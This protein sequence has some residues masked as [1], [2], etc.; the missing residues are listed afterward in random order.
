MGKYVEKFQ[1]PSPLVSIKTD[2]PSAGISFDIYEKIP[3]HSF[4]QWLSPEE[5][6]YIWLSLRTA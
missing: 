3:I 1:F 2:S 6:E 5:I 4:E